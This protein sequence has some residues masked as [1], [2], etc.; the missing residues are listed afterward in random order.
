MN[1]ACYKTHK[2]GKELAAGVG[3][4]RRCRV[5]CVGVFWGVRSVMPHA[6]RCNF[7]VCYDVLMC[8]V[9][10]VDVIVIIK[11]PDSNTVLGIANIWSHSTL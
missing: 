10:S 7:G 3:E 6:V 1:L 9:L 8:D 11:P 5:E 2:K 4:G